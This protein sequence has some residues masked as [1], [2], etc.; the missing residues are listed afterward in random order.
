M[1]KEKEAD[2]VLV[3]STDGRHRKI[4]QKCGQLKCRC[5]PSPVIQPKD[6][7]LKVRREI[8]GRNGKPVTVIFD[9]PK[10]E[11]FCLELLRDLKKSVG[12]GGTYKDAKIEIQGD[13]RERLMATLTKLGF[14]VKLA[15]G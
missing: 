5:A 2:A 12:A 11:K 8:A 1:P 9:L 13:H 10:H 14:R 15:G 7:L 6:H 4:C 3:F